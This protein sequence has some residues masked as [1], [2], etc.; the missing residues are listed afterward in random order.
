MVFSGFII[1]NLI[2][3]IINENI[4]KLLINILALTSAIFL[5]LKA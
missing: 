4:F 1:G 5:I 3:K 2:I